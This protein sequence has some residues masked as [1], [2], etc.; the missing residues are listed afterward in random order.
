MSKQSVEQGGRFPCRMPVVQEWIPVSVDKLSQG[1]PLHRGNAQDPEKL[2]T[3]S[4]EAIGR[5]GERNQ[6]VCHHGHVDLHGDSVWGDPVEPG[7]VQVLLDPS[8][9]FMRSFS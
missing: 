7:H 1:A 3:G 9:R 2:V 6:A 4:L 8:K 5:P